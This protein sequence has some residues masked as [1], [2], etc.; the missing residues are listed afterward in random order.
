MTLVIPVRKQSWYSNVSHHICFL[1]I[2][3]I[4][5]YII[6]IGNDS[7][8]INFMIT[9]TTTFTTSTTTMTII[10]HIQHSTTMLWFGWIQLMTKTRCYDSD[11]LN[12]W[13]R[14]AHIIINRCYYCLN[15]FYLMQAILSQITIYHL[16]DKWFGQLIIR[17]LMMT[18][19]MIITS[20]QQYFTSR[21]LSIRCGCWF[22][23]FSYIVF[24]NASN[25]F[26]PD[27]DTFVFR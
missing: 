8:I 5:L 23:L 14:H 10:I 18:I 19:M 27:L 16:Y 7:N 3:W 22:L 21:F 2:C 13:R 24:I 11:G 9:T 12:W 1:F 17:I 6:T 26:P 4:I 25:C 15:T 20:F